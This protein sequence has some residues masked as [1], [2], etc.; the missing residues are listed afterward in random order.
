M[1][2]EWMQTEPSSETGVLSPDGETY[3]HTVELSAGEAEVG[4]QF[5]NYESGELIIMK[6]NNTGGSALG[7]GDIATF[8]ITLTAEDGP[9]F[10]VQTF[11]LPS[12]GFEYV[13]GSETITK[14]GVPLSGFGFEEYSSPGKYILGDMLEGEEVVI[15]VDME[16][17]D[18][19]EPG[20]YRDLAWAYG[21]NEVI[22][23]SVVDGDGYI[24]DEHF[25]G[26]DVVVED[27][28]DPEKDVNVEEKEVE[29][30]VEVDQNG[31]VLGAA[32]QKLPATGADNWIL[33]FALVLIAGGIVAS[34]REKPGKKIVVLVLF[35]GCLLFP[36]NANAQIANSLSLRVSQPET[37]A[38]KPFKVEYV[39]M[40]MEDNTIEVDCQLKKQGAAN[41]VLLSTEELQEGGDNSTCVISETD[42]NNGSGQY[43]VKVIATAEDGETKEETVS[44]DYDS[45]APDQPAYIEK[46]QNSGCEYEVKFKTADDGQTEYVEVYRSEDK[47]FVIGPSTR[48]KTVSIDPDEEHSF[49]H[50]LYGDDCGDSYYALRSFDSAGNYSDPLVEEIEDIVIKEIVIESEESDTEETAPL[51]A[52]SGAD[53]PAAGQ[54][55]DQE[56]ALEAEEGVEGE[57]DSTEEETMKETTTEEKSSNGE[58][59]G[60]ETRKLS[61]HLIIPAVLAAVVIGFVFF[62]QR[63]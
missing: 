8:S 33:A 61:W 57:E 17:T 2:E 59:L 20:E 5:G 11:D 28:E 52:G 47:D 30:E 48:I 31:Q 22:A 27:P 41:F 16:V 29:K 18:E 44:V 25:V 63:E 32:N 35:L 50:T 49:T 4:V 6:S 24:E 62:S 40:D 56:V 21:D 55:T 15:S 26:T 12:D 14:N 9:V 46:K 13:Q 54:G 23:S 53:V 60:A 10:N 3:C 19:V 39:V 51:V 1:Q 7:I 58:V 38:N 34:L 36:V 42:L 37:P 45:E 43:Q